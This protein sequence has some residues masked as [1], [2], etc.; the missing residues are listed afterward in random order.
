[1]NKVCGGVQCG[2]RTTHKFA[3][4][5]AMLTQATSLYQGGS[6]DEGRLEAK[7]E[8]EHCVTNKSYS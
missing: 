7:E 3:H 8:E 6:R 4:M 5:D 2:V 1:M